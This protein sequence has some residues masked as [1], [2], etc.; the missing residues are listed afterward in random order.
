MGLSR[1]TRRVEQVL[2]RSGSP[3]PAKV[4]QSQGRIGVAEA[5]SVPLVGMALL[6]GY[7]LNIRVL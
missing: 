3:R 6:E 4:I 5:D 1:R 7:E 2:V